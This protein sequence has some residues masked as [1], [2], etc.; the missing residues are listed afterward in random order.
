MGDYH[1]SEG[2]RRTAMVCATVAALGALTAGTSCS[3]RGDER[4]TAVSLD[5][6]AAFT[7]RVVA[8]VQNGGQWLRVVNAS[9]FECRKAP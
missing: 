1:W 5:A 8:C 3:F 9:D 4:T 6:Q 2:T 7:A